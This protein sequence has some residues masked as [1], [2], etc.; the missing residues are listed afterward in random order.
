M[1]STTGA[2]KPRSSDGTGSASRLVKVRVCDASVSTTTREVAGAAPSAAPSPA[3][4][5]GR[6]VPVVASIR[7]SSTG[8]TKGCFSL[9]PGVGA[10]LCDSVSA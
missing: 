6:G 10:Q 1:S 2:L 8:M 9:W 3:R 7:P 4:C 5:K